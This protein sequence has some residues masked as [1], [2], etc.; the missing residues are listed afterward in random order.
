MTAYV[1]GFDTT[2]LPHTSNSSTLTTCNLTTR[3]AI[4]L[5]FSQL[6]VV[7]L[8]NNRSNFERA[9]FYIELWS[10][11]VANLDV[12]GNLVLSNLVTV[13]GHIFLFI[14]LKSVISLKIKEAYRIAMQSVLKYTISGSW[15]SCL[16]FLQFSCKHAEAK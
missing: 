9:Y 11:K 6:P 8:C 16:K 7:A 5:Q 12:C 1:T 14:S 10:F 4:D 3:Y 13:H 15:W 2:K